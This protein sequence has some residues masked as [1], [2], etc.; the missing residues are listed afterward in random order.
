MRD[1]R[2][3]NFNPLRRKEV[4]GKANDYEYFDCKIPWRIMEIARLK[5]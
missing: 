1:I 5:S 3:D 4:N 2:Q